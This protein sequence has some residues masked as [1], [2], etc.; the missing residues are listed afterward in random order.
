MFSTYKQEVVGSKGVVASNH[1]L[2]S[3]AGIEMLTAGGNAIDAA[4]ATMFA[5]SVVEPM[6]VGITGAGFINYYNSRDKSSVTI[7]NYCTAP[8]AA[9]EDM[10]VPVSNEWPDY[11]ET[12]NE[13]NRYGYLSVGVPAALQAW[14][15]VE[16]KYGVLGI[17]RVIRPA[18]R[19]AKEGFAVSDYLS[20]IVANNKEILSIYP[21]SKSLFVSKGIPLKSGDMLSNDDYAKT[22]ED[23]A[24]NG[25][26][27]LTEGFLGHAIAKDM[28][29]NNGIISMDDLNQ[30]K[31]EYREPVRGTYRGYE[32]VGVGPVS[33][34]ATHIIQALNIIEGFDVKEM[35]FGSVEYIHLIAE[36]L[37]MVF[38]DRFRYMGDP[39]FVKVPVEGLISKEYGQHCRQ[40]IDLSKSSSF[41]HDNPAAFATESKNT[42]HITVADETGSVVSMTQTLNDA[43]GSR[44]TVPGTGVLLNNTM[45]NFDP[46]PGTA[47]SIAPGKRVLSS[48]APITVF[49]SGKPFMS[50]GTPGARRIFPSVLQGII[51]VID[52]GMSLQ[53]AV[54]AP[55][56]WTQG[57]NLEL[58]PDISPDVI[59]PLTQKGH[60][61]EGVERV[62]G[63]MNGIL[64]DDTGSI[65]GAACWRADGSPIAVGGGPAIIRGSNPMFR[66]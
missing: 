33:S 57:Q 25:T 9:T 19:F 15:N 44:V 16:E 51:N 43:F 1:P 2:A 27:T 64:F 52:H 49:K 5:L 30:Y 58:E 22:L 54:E 62:A 63:G 59:E 29:S 11:M 17:E 3:L 60:I 47:N 7:D 24:H 42:T 48:M 45:Y 26:A 34:G 8:L 50:L 53:E 18:I 66:V 14:C 13:E 40:K 10:F 35:Q 21:A 12:K 38:A 41:E 31:I 56:V 32:I 36:T 46:H 61:I 20:G 39:D 55:R 6:M 65:H 4:I 23:I 37:K 28:K